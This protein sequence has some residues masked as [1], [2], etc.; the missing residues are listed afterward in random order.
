MVFAGL[1]ELASSAVGGRA[2]LASDD[3]FAGKEHLIAPKPPVFLPDEYTERGKWMDGWESRRRRTPGHD[4]CIVELGVPGV[5]RALDIATHFFLG[6]HPPFASVDACHAPGASPEALRDAITWTP[7]VPQVRLERGAHNPVAVVREGTWTHLRLNIYPDGGVARL[8]A[9]GTPRP[10]QTDAEIDLAALQHGG[11]GLACS[12]SFFSPMDNL[13]RPGPST[14]MGDGWETRRSRPPGRDWVIVALGTPGKVRMAR[15][16]THHFKGNPPARAA[17]DGLYWPGAPASMLVDCGDWRPL[18]PMSP[19]RAHH[20]HDFEA[21]DGGPFTHVRL[22]IEPDGGI[23]RL[24]ILGTPTAATP[25]ERDPL[26]AHLNGLSADEA[27]A[28]LTRCCGARRFVEGLLAARPFASR[29]HLFGDAE[30]VWWHLGDADWLEAFGHHPRIGADVE[31]LRAKF[32]ATADWSAGEQA[33]VASAD[34]AVLQ[35]LADGNRA[36]EARFGYIF[37]VCATGKSAAEM[38]A[39]LRAR[40]DADP[41]AELRVAAGEQAR[42]T[43]LRLEKLIP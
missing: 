42:I 37:I 16:E 18:V 8:R 36:Y 29:T 3:F 23:S 25:G 20:T 38:L 19:L 14:Y 27:R 5:V 6:N 2:V 26:V 17:L 34:E 9:Y 24:R 40:L 1:T 43:R 7:I 30:R 21:I 39:L 32:A 12:D 33:G 22:R 15:I 4:W 28:A 11:R 41:P 10:A 31:A 35:A 13:L